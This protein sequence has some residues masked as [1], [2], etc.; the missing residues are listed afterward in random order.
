MNEKAIKD[1]T[2]EELKALPV[3]EGSW[4][5][6]HWD[7]YRVTSIIILPRVGEELHDSGY[8]C[9]DYVPCDGEIP[10]GRLGSYS[11][12][13]HFGGIGGFNDVNWI[14]NEFLKENQVAKLTGWTIDCLPNGLLRFFCRIPLSLGASLSTFEVFPNWDKSKSN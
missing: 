2:I 13:I 3:I 9:M 12:V 7:K 5:N 4:M 11:D 14:E 1:W 8:T 10:I 6:E